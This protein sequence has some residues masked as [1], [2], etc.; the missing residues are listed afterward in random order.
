MRRLILILAAMAMM[1]GCRTSEGGEFNPTLTGYTHFRHVDSFVAGQ[2]PIVR[3]MLLFNEYVAAE[4]EEDRKEIH[5]TYFYTNRI[6]EGEQ[7]QWHI[8]SSYTELIIDTGGLT[9]DSEGAVWTFRYA[10]EQYDVDNMPSITS[11][12][13]SSD[14][15]RR[16]YTLHIPGKVDLEL[17]IKPTYVTTDD[18]AKQELR[19]D[20]LISGRGRLSVNYGSP[21]PATSIT[22]EATEPVHGQDPTASWFDS[23]S[24]EICAVAS[25]YTDKLQAQ[26]LGVSHVKIFCNGYSREYSYDGMYMY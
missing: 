22:F 10:G 19:F 13:I 23:G 12:G 15:E 20:T 24:W 11:P 7:G 3:V 21:D 6:F 5:D 1:A 9:L 17:S 14:G 18:D 26:Y 4:T 8:V 16:L 2:L 25:D